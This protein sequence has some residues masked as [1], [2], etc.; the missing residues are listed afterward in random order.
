MAAQRGTIRSGG[1]MPTP[2]SVSSS[3]NNR[4]DSSGGFRDKNPRP[5]PRPMG[6]PEPSA[7]G[8][9]GNIPDS[10]ASL[11]PGYD[12]S[13]SL[14]GASKADLRR[15]YRDGTRITEAGSDVGEA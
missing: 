12:Y 7:Q 6:G 3:V 8:A 4:D 11:N 13:G 5:Y 15:G 2:G 9:S 10:N 14:D 1:Q